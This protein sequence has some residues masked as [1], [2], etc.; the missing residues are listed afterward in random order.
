MLEQNLLSDTL[1]VFFS[2][3][4][5]KNGKHCNKVIVILQLERVPRCAWER[6]GWSKMTPQCGSSCLGT[7]RMSRGFP[8]RVCRESIPSRKEYMK[9]IL[10]LFRKRQ[11]WGPGWAWWELRSDRWATCPFIPIFPFILSLPSIFPSLFTE[12]FLYTRHCV[13]CQDRH[14][15]ASV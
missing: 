1:V 7:G 14:G 2:L 9:K 12:C 11:N 10:G 3:L 15:L 4:T 6:G 5:M 13:S 8:S